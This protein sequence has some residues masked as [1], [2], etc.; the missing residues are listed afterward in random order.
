[1]S[2]QHK[3]LLVGI[4]IGTSKIVTIVGEVREGVTQVI[5]FGSHPSNGLKR[6]MVVDI[7]A[8]VNSIQHSIREAEAMAG[9]QIHSAF[10]G[11]AGAHIRSLNSHG[12]VAIR[13]KEVDQA[14]IDRVIDAARAVPIPADQKILHV[15]PQEFIIDGQGSIREPIGM[16]GVR[17][18]AKVHIITGAVSSAQNIVKCIERCG[19]GV[20]DIVLEPLASSYAVLTEDEK[21]LGVALVDIGGGTTDLAI[22]VEGAIRHTVSIPIAGDQVTNDISVALRTPARSAEEIKLAHACALRETASANDLFEVPTAGSRVN[23]KMSRQILA[24]VCEP[25]YEEL[26][27][28]VRTEIRRSGFEDLITS[29]IVLTGGGASIPG[30]IELAEKVFRMPVR[31]GAPERITGLIEKAKSPIYSTAIGLLLYGQERFEQG[32][33]QS[34]FSKKDGLK[35]LIQRMSEWFKRKF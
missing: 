31:L 4:D 34:S 24:E 14:D 16:A 35:G 7:E 12:I 15:L 25:R 30:G 17:L 2:E 13:N 8:T 19:L 26:F 32:N 11:I 29:G 23:R 18:E 27:N 1:M 28:L 21:D 10:T 33:H 3:N 5:G 9:C 22:F 6:G 20:S